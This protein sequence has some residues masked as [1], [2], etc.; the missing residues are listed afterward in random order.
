MMDIFSDDRWIVIPGAIIVWFMFAMVMAYGDL[1]EPP[2]WKSAMVG[3]AIAIIIA[4][5]FIGMGIL[6]NNWMWPI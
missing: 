2:D 5:L 6:F 3:S 4:G 1:G